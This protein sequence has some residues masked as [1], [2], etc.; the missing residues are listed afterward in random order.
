[1]RTIARV[2]WLD[3]LTNRRF[4][5]IA[6]LNPFDNNNINHDDRSVVQRDQHEPH[7]Q[8]EVALKTNVTIMRMC[9]QLA[10]VGAIIWLIDNGM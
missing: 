7:H 3:G 9:G 8:D 10:V 5:K 2:W 6:S 1:M 4:L